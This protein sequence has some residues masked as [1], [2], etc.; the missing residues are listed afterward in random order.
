VTL[1]NLYA[2]GKHLV[3]TAATESYVLTGQPMI[4]IKKDE[5]GACSETRGITLTYNRATEQSTV[6]GIPGLAAFNSKP[7]DACPAALGK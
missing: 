2:T 1:E 3:H 4:S 6:D 7:L 5:K